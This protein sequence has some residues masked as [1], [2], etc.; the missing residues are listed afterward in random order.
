MGCAGW[1]HATLCDALAA[2]YNEAN[3]R[4]GWTAA[5]AAPLLAVLWEHLPWL[6][7][8]HNELDEE[9]QQRLGDLYESFVHSQLARFGL[10]E[11]DLR[12]WAPPGRS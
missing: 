7:P 12:Q 5:R 6:K 4:D 3:G 9:Y 1:D 2:D 11:R 10:T 8:W